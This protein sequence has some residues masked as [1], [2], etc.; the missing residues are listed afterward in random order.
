VPS[1][2]IG[3]SYTITEWGDRLT[4]RDTPSLSGAFLTQLLEGETVT[5]LEGPVD[6]EDYYWWRLRTEEGVEGWAV[7]VYRWYQPVGE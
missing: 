2:Q 4:V 3:S 1:L 5:I 6:A 7:E